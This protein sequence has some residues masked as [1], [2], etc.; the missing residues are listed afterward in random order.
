MLK[1]ENKLY[2]RLIGGLGNQLFAYAYARSLAE[3]TGR[4]LVL[5]LTTGF[6]K[7]KYNRRARVESFLLEYS[8]ASLFE[9]VKFILT[10]F[11]PKMSLKI[12]KSIYQK[13]SNSRNFNYYNLG[14]IQD[15]KFLFI[16]GYFQSFLYFQQYE[17]LIRHEIS[18]K[19]IQTL[20]I[21]DLSKEIERCN[22]ISIH[23]RRIDYEPKLD[24]QYYLN[25]IEFITRT[26]D[27][28]CFFIF[29]DDIKWCKEYFT[30]LKQKT[31]VTFDIQ[32]EVV[33]LWLMTK[34]KHHIIANSSF[35]WWGAWL[36]NYSNKII[37]GP[38]HTQIGVI[39]A[40]YPKGWVAI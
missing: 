6:I 3:K 29:S 7:D 9:K 4:K 38:K 37:I 14:A 20:R 26:I 33:D 16:E 15:I 13:E 19:F 25:G 12:F 40:F 24:I 21:A 27:S 22:S 28:P 35:S 31:F 39:D 34:C 8:E 36:S 32:D 5:D 17:E 18:L 23:V 10:K 11:F 1:N 30:F 2:L